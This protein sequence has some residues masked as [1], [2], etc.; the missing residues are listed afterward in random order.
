MLP[1]EKH[2]YR[3]RESVGHALAEML[4]WMEKHAAPR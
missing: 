4:N 1:H 2:G 3:A